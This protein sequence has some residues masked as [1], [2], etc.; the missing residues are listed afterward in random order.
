MAL[1]SSHS[2]QE[3]W[4][5]QILHQL[6]PP[7][8][9]H[10]VD[11][12][13]FPNISEVIDQLGVSRVFSLVDCRAGY[14]QIPMDPESQAKTAFWGP[15]GLYEFLRMPFGL[16][17]AP[18]T[19]Q[20]AMDQA[21]RG[22]PFARAYMDDVLV[23]SSSFSEHLGHLQTVFDRLRA[24]NIKLHPGKCHFLLPRLPVL[25]HIITA[26]GVEPNPDKVSAILGLQPPTTVSLVRTFL[27]MTGF[28]RHYI[29]GFGRIAT[30]FTMLL[31]NDQP[32]VWGPEQQLAFDTLRTALV[33][34]PCLRRPDFSQP[35]ILSTDW[36]PLAVGAVLAQEH[37]G[38]EHAIAYASK[39]LSPAQQH[40]G[41]T[42]GECLAA[43]WAVDKF[44]PYLYGTHIELRTD[45]PSVPHDCPE[46]LRQ[47]LAVV[48]ASAGVPVRHPLQAWAGQWQRRRPQPP[49]TGPSL[50]APG[51]AYPDGRAG[52]LS[53]GGRL[54]YPRLYC[55]ASFS[56]CRRSCCLRCFF[57]R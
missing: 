23:H 42:D 48:P 18:A 10:R 4:Q 29:K 37:E 3:G 19:Y 35:F 39:T 44:R 51:P 27:G 53:R 56:R 57:P 25:G 52:Q 9:G 34:S 54:Y 2:A 8:C 49:A 47:A 55:H 1:S 26:E 21:L 17:T 50:P 46:S 13:S 33:T 7:Q 31:H 45:R 41:A 38:K 32:W 5:Q 40:Y 30:P 12:Y 11:A 6:S 36:Q 15:D 16:S 43:I 20:R 28:Y 24:C 14:W 22:L